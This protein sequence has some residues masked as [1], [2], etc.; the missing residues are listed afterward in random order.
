MKLCYKETAIRQVKLSISVW[1]FLQNK[2]IL[3]FSVNLKRCTKV[4][5]A[6]EIESIWLLNLLQFVFKG[7][8]IDNFFTH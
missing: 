7:L 1:Y 3:Y 6:I 8:Y 2:N 4:D 5:V